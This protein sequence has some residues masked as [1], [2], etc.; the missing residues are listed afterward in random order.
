MKQHN[1]TCLAELD[2][3]VAQAIAYFETVPEDLFDG[4]LTA[5]EV[6]AHLLF[7]HQTYVQTAGALLNGRSPTLPQGSFA[8]LNAQAADQLST[9]PYQQ[10]LLQLCLVQQ[11]FRDCLQRLGDWER[12]FPIKKGSRHQ[13]TCQRI[14][15]ICCHFRRHTDRMQ[16]AERH[17]AAWVQAYFSESS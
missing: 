3:A 10:M 14:A 15:Q 16:R 1:R 12:P 13:S 5:R 4:Y 6:V 7:W 11:Q 17:G 8:E 2:E 9:V